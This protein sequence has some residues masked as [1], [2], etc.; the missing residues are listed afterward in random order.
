[1]LLFVLER[2][3]LKF[4]AAAPPFDVL[5]KL[6]PRYGRRQTVLKYGSFPI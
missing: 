3:L 1:M 2:T 5:L 6:E 4:N